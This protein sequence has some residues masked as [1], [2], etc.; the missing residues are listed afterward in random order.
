MRIASTSTLTLLASLVW[1]LLFGLQSVQAVPV[2]I[3][4]PV[5]NQL[6]ERNALVQKVHGWHCRL[7]YGR[8]RHRHGRRWHRHKKWHRHLDACY[9]SYYYDGPSIYFYGP[10]YYKRKSY[11]KRSHRPRIYKSRPRRHKKRIYRSEPR[12]KKQ[13][14]KSGPRFKKIWR[15]KRRYR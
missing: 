11:R 6:G 2:S 8:V 4:S 1:L 7:L 15:S 9:D 10:R 14:Y 5:S 3:Q 12:F 13:F